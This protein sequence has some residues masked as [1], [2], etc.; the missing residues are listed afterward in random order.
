M[1]TRRWDIRIASSRPASDLDSAGAL[2][3]GWFGPMRLDNGW[4]YV[5]EIAAT[6]ARRLS[7]SALASERYRSVSGSDAPATTAFPQAGP[8]SWWRSRMLTKQHRGDECALVA[9]ILPFLR[10]IT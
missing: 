2:A 10:Q 4:A 6:G 8:T 7:C 3:G 1:Q 9:V 5:A